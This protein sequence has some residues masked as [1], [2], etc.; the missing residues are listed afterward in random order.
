MA[1]TP[2]SRKSEAMRTITIPTPPHTATGPT[3]VALVVAAAAAFPLRLALHYSSPPSRPMAA[4]IAP[5]QSRV[6]NK[7]T[8]AGYDSF[9]PAAVP[10]RVA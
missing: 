6:E 1:H 7:T 9:P 5:Y 2:R 10:G 3:G 8:H 4:A